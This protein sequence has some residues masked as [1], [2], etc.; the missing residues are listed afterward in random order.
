MQQ[1]DPP[2]AANSFA[3]SLKDKYAKLWTLTTIREDIARKWLMLI[4]NLNEEEII[5]NG[6]G[7][8]DS[9]KVD[10]TW[11]GDPK[12]KYDFYI[13]KYNMYQQLWDFN[14]T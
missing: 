6:I 9:N 10:E 1:G 3:N 5:A 11:E 7:V 12:K 14:V 2:V 4:L 8:L 13:P